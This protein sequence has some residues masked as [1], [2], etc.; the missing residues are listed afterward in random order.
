MR[1]LALGDI[2][3]DVWQSFSI[4]W[5]IIWLRRGRSEPF[6]DIGNRIV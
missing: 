1:Y 3:D 4:G 2:E 6:E 5:S